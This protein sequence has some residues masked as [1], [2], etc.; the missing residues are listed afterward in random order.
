MTVRAAMSRGS[1]HHIGRLARVWGILVIAFIPCS[2]KVPLGTITAWAA[3]PVAHP[4]DSVHAAPT[5]PWPERLVTNWAFGPGESLSYSIGW[6]K[7]VAGSGEMFVDSALDTLGRLCFPI[8]SLVA[9]TPFFSTF[10]KVEDRVFTLMDARQLYPLRF[11]KQLNEGRYHSERTVSFDPEIGVAQTP[12]DT[13]GVPP[14]ILD[15][16]SLLYYV[17]TMALTPGHDVQVDIY[18]GKTVYR[19]TVKILKRERVSV[20]AGVFSTIVVEPLLQSAGLFKSEGKVT[21]WL[22]DDRLHLPVLM[23]SK[24]VVGSFVAELES[25]RLGQIRRY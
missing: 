2:E 7:I 15:D 13:F 11:E 4:S 3:G 19:L 6:E 16:L 1:Q 9:S 5:G 21:V 8:V 25:Y 24:V 10:Y 23:K 18:S 17:R 22:T 14:Y 12:A 20:R